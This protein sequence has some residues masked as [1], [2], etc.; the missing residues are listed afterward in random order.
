MF[1]PVLNICQNPEEAGSTTS[2]GMNLPVEWGQAGKE[3]K[4]LSA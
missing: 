3:Q 1:Q 2:E 4:H